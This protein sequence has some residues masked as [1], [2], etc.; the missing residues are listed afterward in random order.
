MYPSIITNFKDVISMISGFSPTLQTAIDAT[1]RANNGI[2]PSWWG[3]LYFQNVAGSKTIKSEV[4]ANSAP[5]SKLL[6]LATTASTVIFVGGW[7][8][9]NGHVSTIFKL[10]SVVT[11]F[12]SVLSQAPLFVICDEV[13]PSSNDGTSCF[14][15]FVFLD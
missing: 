8:Y 9:T 5:G 2:I 12:N 6:Q 10:N 15:Y 3:Q 7:Q 13:V 11:C 1:A 4:M 14:G